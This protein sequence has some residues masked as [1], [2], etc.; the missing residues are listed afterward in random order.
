MGLSDLAVNCM[1]ITF[2]QPI[3]QALL[4]TWKYCFPGQVPNFLVASSSAPDGKVVDRLFGSV[5]PTDRLLVTN[6]SENVLR[7]EQVSTSHVRHPLSL[8]CV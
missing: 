2:S 1:S 5:L 3:R 4:T 7:M 6:S 8:R